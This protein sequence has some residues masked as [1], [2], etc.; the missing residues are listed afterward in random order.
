VPRDPHGR[1]KP[2]DADAGTDRDR[3]AETGSGDAGD[4]QDEGATIG[5]RTY[6]KSKD[7]RPD[8]PQ[9]VIGMAVTRD[10]IPWSSWPT[11]PT[12]PSAR[13]GWA[14]RS[15]PP[16]RPPG[17]PM[18]ELS[19]TS[20]STK[21]PT[22]PTSPSPPDTST[23][24]TPPSTTQ[25]HPFWDE[26]QHAWIEA[27]SLAPG[28]QLHTPDGQRATVAVVRS[29]T[30]ANSMYNLTVDVT[31]TYYVVAGD[32]PV[33]VHN[34][35]RTPDGK[36]GKSDGTSGRVGALDER[37]T[38]D[39]LETDGFPVVRGQVHVQIP[40]VGLRIYDGAVQIDGEWYGIETKGGGSPLTPR[41]QAADN[42][43]NTPGNTAASSGGL[44]LIGTF[45]SW[46][47]NPAN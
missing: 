26:T 47:P 23:P 9:I 6:G 17:R 19:P 37:T 31:H 28:D 43:L 21:T 2:T 4:E 32:T 46:V 20:S 35:C 24:C 45:G 30:E 15:W 42:W 38:L 5:F 25:H 16:T 41:Q 34:A 14:T 44:T 18:R 22:L 1:I 36:F 10:G 12:N 29:S 3:T 39:Q 33:L 7:H 27:S 11:A 40:G 8:L 13:S